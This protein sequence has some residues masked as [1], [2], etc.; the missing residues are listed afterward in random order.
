MTTR[1][2]TPENETQSSW[3]AVVGMD[4]RYPGSPDLPAYWQLLLS[5][6]DAVT[7]LT[8]DELLGAGVPA[9]V[10]DDPAYIRRTARLA[11]IDEFDAELFGITPAAAAQMDPQQRLFLQCAHGALEDAALD[12]WSVGVRTGVFASTAT[13]TYLL[14]G[15]LVGDPLGS[16]A[17]GP[18]MRTVA[19]AFGNDKDY[20]ATR[21][22]WTFNL[23]GPSV[24]VQTACS[25]ALVAVHL[26]CQSLL[27][28]E[29]DMALAGGVSVRVPQD[30]GYF[31]EPGSILSP[32]GAC[33][34]FDHAADGTL[35]GSGVGLV[36]LKPYLAA[37]EDRNAIHAIIRGSAINNDGN[38]K[39]GFSAPS[40]V[41]QGQVVADALAVAEVTPEEVGFIEA[42]GTGTSLGD[43][44][45]VKA[46]A[47]RFA[48]T[49][50]P[51]ILGSVKGNVG[52]LEA[53]AGIASLHKA[54]LAL[55]HGV[56]PGTA[57]YVRPNPE[58]EL[59]HTPFV[60]SADP[61]EWPMAGRPRIAGVT[62][63]GVGGT[64]V[65]IVLQAAP[66][67]PQTP[68][69][70]EPPT[71][72]LR[73]GAAS[74]EAL[75]RVRAALADRLAMN[76][77]RL[78]DVAHTLARRHT[79]DRVRGAVSARSVDEAVD[80][81]RRPAATTKALPA[82]PAPKL[83]FLYTGQGSQF[84][85]MGLPLAR[86]EPS[87]GG[88]LH[89]AIEAL[90][91]ESG[92]DL[93]HVLEFGTQ[94]EINRTDVTQALLFSVQYAFTR[95]LAEYG[96]R[97]DMVVGHSIGEFAAAVAA[98]VLDLGTAAR[99][100]CVR[101]RAM[102]QCPPGGMVAFQGAPEVIAAVA[103][104]E[105]VD[106]AVVNSPR[107]VVLS[108]ASEALK[109]VTDALA[110]HGITGRPVRTSHGFHSGSMRKAAD[111]FERAAR[112][113]VF[114]VPSLPMASNVTGGWLT[115]QESLD[116]RRWGRHI[117][118][119]VR[120]GDNID[121]VLSCGPTILV[122]MGPGRSLTAAARASERWTDQQH[123]AVLTI[124]PVTDPLPGE[125]R[126]AQCLGDLWA[127]GLCVQGREQAGRV[128][129]LPTYPFA[130]SSHWV[131]TRS[132]QVSVAPLA[133][134]DPRHPVEASTTYSVEDTLLALVEQTLGVSGV[135]LDDDFFGL[136]GDSVV[137]IQ[138]ASEVAKQGWA[139]TPQDIFEASTIRA[140]AARLAADT[141]DVGRDE[142]GRVLVDLTPTQLRL[143]D[144]GVGPWWRWRVAL[145]LRASG[146]VT[147]AALADAVTLLA[148]RHEVLRLDVDE[149]VAP[150]V[151]FLE[152]PG[153]RVEVV[154]HGRGAVT[155]AEEILA[156]A[157]LGEQRGPALQV[158]L[159]ACPEGGSLIGVVVA[160]ALVDTASQQILF[161]EL[162]RLL[163][164]PSTELSPVRI[165][166]SD[167]ANLTRRLANHPILARDA[168]A[169]A[170]ARDALNS[171][172]SEPPASRVFVRTSVT[173]NT[174]ATRGL[175]ARQR[176][177]RIRM[178]AI[179]ADAL[180][181]SLNAVL[182]L[183]RPVVE[184]EGSIRVSR[185]R[186]ID[187]ART[188]GWFTTIHPVVWAPDQMIPWPALD[189]FA[190][191][192]MRHLRG[193]PPTKDVTRGD[194]LLYYYA[195]EAGQSD[196]GPLVV[197]PSERLA[198]AAVPALGH[199]LQVEVVRQG[200]T[201]RVT[202]WADKAAY[203]KQDLSRLND[204]FESAL[205]GQETPDELPNKLRADLAAELGL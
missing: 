77:L 152:D 17:Y 183:V 35:F 85:G 62:S 179:L 22:S 93:A 96:V 3:I 204:H 191:D 47:R 119:T 80:Q 140:L 61:V 45:E 124:G 200:D 26:A 32:T 60:I 153:R 9:S 139:I 118:E 30:V 133:E 20:I 104:E 150:P 113:E 127:A 42:H 54:I 10:I 99:L 63:L 151:A 23:T 126:L 114:R 107:D 201:I 147:S 88:P 171:R 132:R 16:M 34:P 33:R 145:L 52:H 170:V 190:W 90:S 144:D 13:S 182:G 106:V 97:P 138:L 178:E 8:R 195:Q 46:L 175:L 18:N 116:A 199:G 83:A 40:V 159:W 189:G 14:N 39:M 136:G 120:F 1:A 172:P 12:P 202:W 25:S 41:M 181:E 31:A 73:L 95:A 194:A 102:V 27:L 75:G 180:G 165:N 112:G 176:R 55:Q 67:E 66:A 38:Q 196:E 184:V 185:L 101:G 142:S 160:H 155:A 123:R 108:G 169:W 187:L 51:C 188:V 167:W 37:L 174:Q 58:L 86:R 103:E 168:E 100:V 71:A 69:H 192:A 105:G 134:A 36:V 162:G 21:L 78:T 11:G 193:G 68:L 94:E 164:D 110:G 56:V 154:E 87:F 148:A 143:L 166:W 197:V 29:C 115:P 111:A 158:H 44:I 203:G 177:Q 28:G 121:M 70:A 109:R 156:E 205:A 141:V 19:L 49:S 173:L 6:S 59:E 53:A 79:T 157:C 7:E 149:T 98:G 146:E 5:G 4:G 91:G 74:T 163:A 125:L 117:R 122:E 131:A 76:E 50:G 186:G 137:A 43:P 82:A 198:E 2:A 92:L 135:T 15:L 48:G 64:N 130:R 84:P 65:H 161:A 57:H 89:D 24:S 128:V 81:L 72:T 129:A